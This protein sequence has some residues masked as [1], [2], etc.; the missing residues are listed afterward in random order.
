MIKYYQILG[1]DESASNE[2]IERKFKQLSEELN[3]KNNDNLDFF[4][5]EYAKVQ[6]AYKVLKKKSISKNSETKNKEFNNK[7]SSKSKKLHLNKSK[8]LNYKELNKALGLSD[9]I[10]P[11]K[12]SNNGS[13]I[14]VLIIIL[15]SLF[16]VFYINRWKDEPSKPI[17]EKKETNFKK[18]R[19]KLN[20]T[21]KN[22]KSQSTVNSASII[23]GSFRSKSNAYKLKNILLSEGFKNIDIS[24]FNKVYRVSINVIGTKEKVKEI[25]NKVKV[26]HKDAWVSY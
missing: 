13:K 16:F 10:K 4:K 24:K 19:K 20:N 9:L 14:L 7:S 6:E 26:I 21:I 3:P 12:E 23:V 8:P 25:Y 11:K 1:L 17:I 18:K 5:E 2:E 22:S 15:I